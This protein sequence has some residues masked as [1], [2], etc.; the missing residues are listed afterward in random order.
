MAVICILALEASG[1]DGP[2]GVA[3]FGP[4]AGAHGLRTLAAGGYPRPI[5]DG[6]GWA[7]HGCG[8]AGNGSPKMATGRLPTYPKQSFKS[9]PS[10][11][12]PNPRPLLV[13][14]C[15]PGLRPPDRRRT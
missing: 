14:F 7:N 9:P 12:P 4:G 8:T 11:Y 1:E 13:H 6:F 3:A 10:K 2:I 15:L 5:R